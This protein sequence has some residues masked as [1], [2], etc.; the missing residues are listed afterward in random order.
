MNYLLTDNG[1]LRCSHR[2]P[3]GGR[4]NVHVT[5]HFVRINGGCLHVKNNTVNCSM[6]SLSC[7]I[8]QDPSKGLFPCK[9]T[10]SAVSGYSRFVS[11]EGKPICLDSI[12]GN[13]L[14]N[15]AGGTYSVRNSGQRFVKGE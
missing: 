1:V 10:V 9:K 3:L 4:V 6:D 8:I 14:S 5:Q 11:I 12:T 2:G 15:P 7:A 13:T